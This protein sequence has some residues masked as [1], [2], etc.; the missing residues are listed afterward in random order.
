MKIIFRVDADSKK[1]V[2]HLM[3]CL[4]LGQSL[5]NSNCDVIFAVRP[6]TK[7]ICLT[8]QDWVGRIKVIPDSVALDQEVQWLA[9]VVLSE[10][11]DVLCLDGYQFDHQYRQSLFNIPCKHICFDDQN[12]FIDLPTHLV[13][14]GARNASELGYQ[15]SAPQA[16]HCI[17]DK[18]RILRQEF[19]HE[20]EVPWSK[21]SNLTLVFGGSDP[22]NVTL[23]LLEGLDLI[24]FKGNI[25]VVTGPAYPNLQKLHKFLA[26]TDLIVEHQHDC[27]QIARIFSQSKLT[28]TAA[29]G[30]QFEVMVCGSPAILVVVADNQLNA[31]R[32]AAQEGWCEMLDVRTGIP[33]INT[34]KRIKQLWDKNENLKIMGQRALLLADK[35]GAARVVRALIAL[36][37][38]QKQ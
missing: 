32:Q 21:K 23:P 35:N 15:K 1:G 22:A 13:I 37:S 8:R 3:R 14:N 24:E 30:S 29:G 9:D 12:Q 19:I 20:P 28:I 2:G 10:A 7:K 38:E 17:G 25:T 33:A 27:Q 5:F 36:I 6:N 31:T 34:A 4:A 26:T 16:V 11:V 18:F